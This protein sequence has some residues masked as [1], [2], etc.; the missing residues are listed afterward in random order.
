M[1]SLQGTARL[2]GTACA[3]A[4]GL[5]ATPAAAQEGGRFGQRDAFVLSVERIVGF[6]NQKFDEDG[7][8]VDSTGLQP[9]Y[10]GSLGL[11]SMSS[12]GL[13]FGALFGVTRL[14][15]DQ[16]FFGDPDG[17]EVTLVQLRPRI[18]YAGTEK[19]GRFGY[20]VRGGPTLVYAHSEDNDSQAFAAGFEAYA[21]FFPAPRI[22]VMLGPHAEFH[23]AGSGDGDPYYKSTGLTAGIMGEF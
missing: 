4:L 6:Q 18:G 15:L 19:E 12:S 14:D 11:F 9:V 3:F 1:G 10:W 17:L 20:W 7:G 22:G 16:G 2:A 13:N 5:A 8:S 23:L 21:V